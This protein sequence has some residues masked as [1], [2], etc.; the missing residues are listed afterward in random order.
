MT[1]AFPQ[2]FSKVVRTDTWEVGHY[3][4]IKNSVAMADP[5]HPRP[6]RIPSAISISKPT[7]PDTFHPVPAETGATPT[8]PE[9]GPSNHDYTENAPQAVVEAI[10]IERAREEK[11]GPP[12]MMVGSFQ[13]WTGNDGRPDL[14]CIR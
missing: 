6:S 11:E 9:A 4:S 2:T 7:H 13:S 8:E 10:A 3:G 14:P 12:D 5:P 1:G